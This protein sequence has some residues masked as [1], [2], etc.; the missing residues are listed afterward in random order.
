MNFLKLEF[1]TRKCDSPGGDG[2]ATPIHPVA[3][4]SPYSLHD[5]E[6]ALERKGSGDGVGVK[7]QL[8]VN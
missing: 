6:R 7:N 2:K 8:T 5:H 1:R 4:A 3:N